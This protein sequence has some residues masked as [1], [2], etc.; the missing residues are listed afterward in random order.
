M[1]ADELIV[2]INRQAPSGL[3]QADREFLRRYQ[4]VLGSSP[5]YQE[6]ISKAISLLGVEHEFLGKIQRE[7]KKGAPVLEIRPQIAI[8]QVIVIHNL[9]AQQCHRIRDALVQAPHGKKK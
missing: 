4:V 2:A 8:S 1:N 7:P 9:D 3:P 6:H 5:Y